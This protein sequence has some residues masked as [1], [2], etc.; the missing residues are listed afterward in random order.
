MGALHF[1][2]PA[3]QFVFTSQSIQEKQSDYH[4]YLQ[5]RT[6]KDIYK[7]KHNAV[8]HIVGKL[9]EI[10]YNCFIRSIEQ[11]FPTGGR[12][13]PSWYAKRSS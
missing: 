11:A 4:R 8:K 3:A 6:S 2:L 5:T 9:D 13:Y 7:Q 1:A 12:R 10:S